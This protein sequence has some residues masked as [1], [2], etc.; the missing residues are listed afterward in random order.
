M[1][2]CKRGLRST[3]YIPRRKQF[4]TLP[5]PLKLPLEKLELLQLG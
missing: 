1:D 5:D 2:V 4:G 3:H